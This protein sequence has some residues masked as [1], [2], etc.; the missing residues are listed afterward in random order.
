VDYRLLL[1]DE[2]EARQRRRPEYSGRA[3]SRDLGLTPSHLVH[4]FNLEKN[5]SE[6]KASEILQR[7]PWSED[8]KKVFWLSFKFQT[9]RSPRL[10][11]QYE[12]ELAK[13]QP[14]IVRRL[15]KD[16]EFR[17]VADWHHYAI[18]EILRTEGAR[19]NANW[20]AAKLGISSE[21][22]K[23]SL[24]RLTRIGLLSFEDGVY[25]VQ[26]EFYSSGDTPSAAIRANHNQYMTLALH[27]L[28]RQPFNA[29]DFSGITMAIDPDRLPEA[30]RRIREF[31]RQLM[32]FLEGGKKARVYRLN[33]QLFALDAAVK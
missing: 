10:K 33:V 25:R 4:L 28:E 8:A 16:D 12:Q 13:F 17:L 21:V 15:F 7:L 30:K 1:K 6:N 2:M 32:A 22:A 29:R 20:I 9:A 5:L 27:A 24:E 18:V 26:S 19:S 23:S 11:Q 31:R 14:T 3:F